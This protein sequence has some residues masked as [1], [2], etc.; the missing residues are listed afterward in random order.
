MQWLQNAIPQCSDTQQG[1][2][3]QVQSLSLRIKGFVP[4]TGHPNPWDLHQ[5]DKVPKHLA[6]ENNGAYIQGAH[7]AARILDT[8]VEG[9]MCRFTGSR[10]KH[11]CKFEK[12]LEGF[13][14][15]AVVENL[16]ANAGDTGSSPGLGRSHM[17]RSN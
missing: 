7:G 5:R 6:L 2:I 14:G 4:H 9:L 12:W 1:D 15:G 16:P 10:N 11:K 3:S 8:P 13:P 17:P